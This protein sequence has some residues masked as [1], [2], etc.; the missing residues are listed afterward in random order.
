M[1]IR[2][3]LFTLALLPLPAAAQDFEANEALLM[4]LIFDD[5]V[6]F[7]KDGIEPFDGLK[8]EEPSAEEKSLVEL[9]GKDLSATV[10]QNRTYL[11]WWGTVAGKKACTIFRGV[12]RQ[13]QQTSGIPLQRLLDQA[14]LRAKDLGLEITPQDTDSRFVERDWIEAGVDRR[15]ALT[16]SM[17]LNVH[18]DV[19]TIV[20]VT[21]WMAPPPLLN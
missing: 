17:T 14:D 6:G 15:K 21:T 16:V 19:A 5:C 1:L 3:M 20:G 7:V 8:T 18:Q 11:A 12:E 13:D 10:I 9:T 4:R 2:A